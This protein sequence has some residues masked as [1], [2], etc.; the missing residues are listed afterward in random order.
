MIASPDEGDAVQ[1][2]DERIDQTLV[3]LQGETSLHARFEIL[4]ALV[5]Y[6][7]G[8]ISPLDG[9]SNAELEHLSLP[10]PLRRW[11]SWAG[12]RTEI[13]SGQNWFFTPYSPQPYLKPTREDGYLLFQRENQGVYEWAT[14]PEGEDP[15]VFGR[16]SDE[17]WQKE[18]VSLSQHLILNCLFEAIICHASYSA[19]TAW[20]KEEQLAPILEH[21]SGLAIPAWH[22]PGPTCFYFGGGAFMAVTSNK[23]SGE[24]TGHSIWLGAKHENALKFLRPYVSD[25]WEHAEL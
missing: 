18:E 10:D 16:Y 23:P 25:T 8:A 15:P 5:E 12:R 9:F 6:W 3:R 19:S 4:Q 11:Y 2:R 21:F 20:I 7:H 13:M 17:A 22:W 14:L 1:E 24:E